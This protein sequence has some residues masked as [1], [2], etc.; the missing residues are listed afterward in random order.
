M[1]SF[2]R[3][4]QK[5]HYIFQDH[6]PCIWFFS[7]FTI[8]I[9]GF[10][11]FELKQNN[12]D[13]IYWKNL[14]QFCYHELEQFAIML[15]ILVIMIKIIFV[16]VII[17]SNTH[18]VHW[19]DELTQLEVKKR[20]AD[21]LLLR[22]IADIDNIETKYLRNNKTSDII[23]LKS[24]ILAHENMKKSVENF[25]KDARKL[26]TPN[27]VEITLPIEEVYGVL[28]NEM[29]Y[30]RRSRFC[31]MDIETNEGLIKKLVNP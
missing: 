10:L 13:L 30:L 23:T 28:E 24:F 21:F 12:K 8:V 26:M 31:N 1:T 7:I 18:T 16:G 19:Y 11:H 6:Y 5:L 29:L 3:I 20:Y 4:L 25:R 15:I 9:V 2:R 14:V 17:M 22:L 27:E